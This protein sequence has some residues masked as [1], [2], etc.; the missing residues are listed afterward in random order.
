MLTDAACLLE[1]NQETLHLA[2]QALERPEYRDRLAEWETPSL[3]KSFLRELTALMLLEGMVHAHEGD[4]AAAIAAIN[5]T[6]I[7]A[8]F[9]ERE[10]FMGQYVHAAVLRMTYDA[11]EHCLS[12]CTF[13][14]EQLDSVQASMAEFDWHGFARSFLIADRVNTIESIV[15]D[16]NEPLMKEPRPADERIASNV[17]SLKSAWPLFYYWG[18]ALQENRHYWAM[19]DLPVHEAYQEYKSRGVYIEAQGQELFMSQGALAWMLVEGLHGSAREWFKYAARLDVART[20]VA[21]ERYR[22]AKS[23]LP[24]SLEELAPDYI[25]EVP[26][27]P[28]S[29]EPLRYVHDAESFT[30]YSIGQDEKDDGGTKH[31]GQD[32]RLGDIPFEVQRKPRRAAE[33]GSDPGSLPA[34]G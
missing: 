8:R 30:V 1:A 13:S 29:G 4:S 9:L 5:D 27:D 7:L 18:I 26:V 34:Q 16:Y 14:P 10:P 12:S 21:V 32:L 24:E 23:R 25:D 28:Y 22:L 6:F 19:K 33:P 11:L 20:A 15:G 31:V 3:S 2:R 17:D